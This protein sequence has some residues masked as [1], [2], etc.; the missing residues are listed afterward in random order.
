MNHKC[1]IDE[2][3][4]EKKISKKTKAIIPVHL[5]EMFVNEKI[6]QIAK[7]Y[8]ETKIIEDCAQS[9]GASYNN[10]FTGNFGDFGCFSF[11]PTKIFRCLWRWRLYCL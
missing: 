7:K 3:K 9:L 8:K 2:N 10:R 4:I 1:L 11:Y 6:Q 5:Y